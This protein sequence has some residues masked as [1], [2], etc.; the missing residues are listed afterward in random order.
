VPHRDDLG[1]AHARIEALEHELERARADADESQARAAALER[2]A[3]KSPPSPSSGT[4]KKRRR[5]RDA[6]TERPDPPPAPTG[7][8][9]RRREYRIGVALLAACVYAPTAVAFLLS[10]ESDLP[11]PVTLIGPVVGMALGV[12]VLGVVFRAPG[13]FGGVL[14]TLLVSALMLGALAAGTSTAFV[15]ELVPVGVAS[16]V[17]RVAASVVGV[18][19][20]VVVA[21]RWIPDAASSPI[22]GD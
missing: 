11:S 19:V 17:A 8:W 9:Q 2:S 12:G 7:E 10:S 20:G 16:S 4:S 13:A 15:G 21:A 1:A 6:A 14:V 18:A 3:A 5:K 22:E